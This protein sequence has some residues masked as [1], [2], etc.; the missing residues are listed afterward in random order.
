MV[1]ISRVVGLG[2]LAL[3]AAT[4]CTTMKPQAALDTA[5]DAAVQA[6]PAAQ[7]SPATLDPWTREDC[8][9]GGSLNTSGP[10]EIEAP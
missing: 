8:E 3:I 1:T 4:G 6:S 7:A 10:C 9:V 5:T 2:M